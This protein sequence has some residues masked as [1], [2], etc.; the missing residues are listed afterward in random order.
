MTLRV[1]TKS[2]GRVVIN[3]VSIAAEWEFGART[4]Y[5]G[6]YPPD[7]D[8]SPIVNAEG[9]VRVELWTG[10]VVVGRA[11]VDTTVTQPG[12]DNPGPLLIS[13]EIHWAPD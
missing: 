10:P 4:K 13:G 2:K 8:L 9:P 11:Y 12:D 3:G 5:S 7:L 6:I 1:P